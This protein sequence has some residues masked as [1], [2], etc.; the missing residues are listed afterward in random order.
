MGILALIGTFMG[1]AEQRK[2]LEHLVA[3]WRVTYHLT[4]EQAARI[5]KIELDFHGN[6]NPFTSRDSGTAE[7]NIA[8]YLE[9]SRAM[10]PEDGA[11]FLR[12]RRDN[13][14]H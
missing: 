13:G 14:R 3:N 4:D 7:E 2:A 11:R 12:T 10:S 6:G 8:H 9:I 5:R 1:I